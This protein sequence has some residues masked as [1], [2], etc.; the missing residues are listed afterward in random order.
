[1]DICLI[2]A[3]RIAEVHSKNIFNHTKINFK[4]VVDINLNA[5]KKIAK[6][7]NEREKNS[8]LGGVLRSFYIITIYFI[9]FNFFL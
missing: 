3:G 2:G 4:Y 7:Q 1:M 5:A 6:K 8:N 9:F